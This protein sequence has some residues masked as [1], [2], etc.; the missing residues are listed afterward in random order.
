[1]QLRIA[2]WL[3]PLVE[4]DNRLAQDGQRDEDGA[5]LTANECGQVPSTKP[6]DEHC[7]PVPAMKE[8]E[9]TIEDIEQQVG[10]CI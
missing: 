9:E 2:S 6:N 1:M 7:S 5:N 8:P 10:L 4:N 3:S